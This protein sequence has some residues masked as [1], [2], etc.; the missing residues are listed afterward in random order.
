MIK[1]L[2]TLWSLLKSILPTSGIKGFH[3]TVGHGDFRHPA[4]AKL[5]GHRAV[6]INLGQ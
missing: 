4:N 5:A 2:L 1:S 3:Q 6:G